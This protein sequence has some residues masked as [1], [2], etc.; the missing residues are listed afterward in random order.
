[1]TAFVSLFRGLNVGGNHQVKID[2]LKALHESLGLRNVVPYIQSGNVVFSRDDAGAAQLDVAQL[3]GRIEDSFEQ[4]FGFHS[5]VM[6]RS[7]AEWQ[8]VIERNPFEGQP[9]KEPKWV[10]VM[11]L[12]ASPEPAAWEALRVS[13]AG[14]EE[15]LLSDQ[16]LY[17]YYAEGIG[18]SKLSG[19]FLEKKLKTLGTARNWNTILQLQTLL[20]RAGQSHLT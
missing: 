2:A 14:P 15:L 12:A 7:A 10:L 3:K 18:R 20:Q 5:E 1:M 11:F 19:A 6:L 4:H 13:H 16:E 9:G 17:L 8:Q